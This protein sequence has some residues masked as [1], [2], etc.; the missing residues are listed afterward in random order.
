MQSY[1]S[2]KGVATE[3]GVMCFWKVFL[4]RRFASFVEEFC[5][6]SVLYLEISHITFSEY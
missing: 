2:S 4:K 3:M 6:F 5:L 1:E